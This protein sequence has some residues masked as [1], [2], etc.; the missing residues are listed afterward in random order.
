[1]RN[2][3]N[4]LDDKQF[5]VLLKIFSMNH[6][7]CFE[8]WIQIYAKAIPFVINCTSDYSNFKLEFF[9]VTTRNLLSIDFCR[10]EKLSVKCNKWLAN[11]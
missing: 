6:I 5:K 8:L 7:R 3:H 9:Y 1:M 10:Q 4:L 11:D 2:S